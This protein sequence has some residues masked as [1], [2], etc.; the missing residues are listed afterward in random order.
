[1]WFC[2]VLLMKKMF[3]M[4]KHLTSLVALIAVNAVQLDSNLP[5][6]FFCREFCSNMV[7]KRLLV[8]GECGN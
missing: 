2:F 5:Q 7:T 6:Q 8:P 4:Q 3:I 1:M